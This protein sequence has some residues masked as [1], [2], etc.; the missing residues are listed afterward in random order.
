MA[1]ITK[2]CECCGKSMQVRSADVARGWGRFCSKT[3]KAS[4]QERRTGQHAAHL[5]ASRSGAYRPMTLAELAGG[6]NG[7]S[8]RDDDF[9]SDK[10][11]F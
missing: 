3:C 8:E 11:G 6:G 7:Y 10:G 1:T 9:A 4:A 2:H 5:R